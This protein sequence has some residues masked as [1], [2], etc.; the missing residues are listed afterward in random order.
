[1]STPRTDSG[2]PY[3]A[4]GRR[5]RAARL[6]AGH[7]AIAALVRELGVNEATYRAA[8]AGR[9]RLDDALAQLAIERYG[10]T[11][12]FLLRGVP[13]TGKDLQISRIARSLKR[14]DEGDPRYEPSQVSRRLHRARTNS[15]F[16]SG[17]AVSRRNGW[18]VT[19]YNAHEQFARPIP[20]DH[21]FQYA[22][23][24]DVG[25]ELLLFDEGPGSTGR[26][27]A[28]T[29]QKLLTGPTEL[30]WT[31][32][33]SGSMALLRR[34]R[35]RFLYEGRGQLKVEAGL[36]AVLGVAENTT[37]GSFLHL[38]A[39][40][41]ADLAPPQPPMKRPAPRWMLQRSTPPVWLI[42]DGLSLLPTTTPEGQFLD[43]TQYHGTRRAP[44]LLG[45]LL[46]TV[47][48]SRPA[49]FLFLAGR[50]P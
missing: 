21:A 18:S 16:R 36:I 14:V 26:T 27:N 12:S 30:P 44:L 9:R 28:E 23:G 40:P 4:T 8:E 46:A 48:I 35:R 6:F 7:F 15:G 50:R 41:Q 49:P 45:R 3:R 39:H 29:V 34:R 32:A 1:M 19:S 38:L 13:T 20:V 24:I 42:S 31:W 11:R 43:P 5:L 37:A 17:L 25:P 47:P 2:L 33:V 10:V 22:R